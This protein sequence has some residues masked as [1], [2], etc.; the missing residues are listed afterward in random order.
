M[1]DFGPSWRDGTAFI[2]VVNSIRPGKGSTGPLL[3]W[4]VSIHNSMVAVYDDLQMLEI[5]NIDILLTCLHS[6]HC[7]KC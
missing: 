2:A 6:L 3:L 7:N 4:R 1:R 5:D